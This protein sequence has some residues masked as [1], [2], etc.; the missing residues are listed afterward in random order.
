MIFGKELFSLP[1]TV[2]I[3]VLYFFLFS[4]A[5]SS[6]PVDE[7]HYRIETDSELLIEGSSNINEFTCDCSCERDFTQ[8]SLDITQAPGSN[9]FTFQNARLRLT[10]TNLNCGHKVMNEDLYEALR[11]DHYPY[12]YIN[13]L[14]AEIPPQKRFASLNQWLEID[15]DTRIT[16]AGRE[17]RVQIPARGRRLSDNRFHFTGK[18]TV[19]MTD[20]GIKPPKAMLGL[21]KV[22][23]EITIHLDLVV[24]MMDA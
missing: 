11:V 24:R 15:A 21:I 19:K 14:Q 5:F 23:D 6:I 13:L 18:V 22:N 12:I 10:T 4:S 3:S 2:A 1:N 20:F 8:S 7:H 16:L 9:H 17:R